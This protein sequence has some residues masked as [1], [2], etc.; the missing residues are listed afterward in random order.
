MI[1]RVRANKPRLLSPYHIIVQS[2]KELCKFYLQCAA[3]QHSKTIFLFSPFYLPFSS[4]TLRFLLSKPI[5]GLRDVKQNLI[6]SF[7][8]F[9]IEFRL[10]QKQR[11]T[12]YTLTKIVLPSYIHSLLRRN[13]NKTHVR[14]CKH[15]HVHMTIHF[16]QLQ[17]CCMLVRCYFIITWCNTIYFLRYL[18]GF[19]SVHKKIL[20]FISFIF[21]DAALYPLHFL[22]MYH[23]LT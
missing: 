12:M 14:W 6:K 13:I 18:F 19:Y 20:K 23:I 9:E 11:Y 16:Q 1:L 8:M 7:P 5:S 2:K 17:L 15:K 22:F 21:L 10:W 4:D 3:Q